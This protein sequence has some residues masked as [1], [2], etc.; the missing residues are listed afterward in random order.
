MNVLITGGAGYIGSNVALSLI[1]ANHKV[2]IIDNLITGSKKVIPTKA[3]FYN[4]D[5]SD[6]TK[7]LEILKNNKFDLVMHFAGLIKVEESLKYPEKYYLYNIQKAKTFL[8][9]CFSSGLNKVI[10]S[11][12]AGVYGKTKINVKV[13][14][15]S[16]LKP[17]NPYAETKYEVEKYLINLSSKNKIKCIILRYFNVAGVDEKNRSGI[18]TLNSNNLIK[19]VC[20]TVVQKRK[21]FTI[22]GNDYDT[23]DGTPVRDFIHISDLANMHVIAAKDIH[24][25]GSSDI[26]N[27]G[28]GNGYSVKEVI[29]EMESVMKNKINFELGPRRHDDIP[30]SVAD[31]K[32]FKEKFN[33]K[34]RY[35]NLNHILKSSLN[36]EKKLKN[37]I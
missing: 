7:I 28:Y 37:K 21:K 14:E 31:S 9:S 13:S 12:T 29:Q 32:K 20:E 15:T 23:K 36:W 8:Q 2:T 35:D 33:W 17:S 27:C 4:L 24:S 11:S 22:N 30:Y 34:P 1:D 25:N 6:E 16:D 10:F 3:Q 19:A 26:Y 18:M 5:I